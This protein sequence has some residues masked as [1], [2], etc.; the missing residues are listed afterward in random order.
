MLLRLQR[1]RRL[2]QRTR[3]IDALDAVF[4]AGEKLARRHPIVTGIARPGTL[5]AN[6]IIAT[7]TEA[8]GL[9]GKQAASPTSLA[10]RPDPWKGKR[11]MPGGRHNVPQTRYMPAPV[12]AR[13]NPDRET[14]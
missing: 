7:M 3:H 2:E 4:A 11:C 1:T 9:N 6:Q 5:S 13:F 8:G 12:A 10:R 14:A